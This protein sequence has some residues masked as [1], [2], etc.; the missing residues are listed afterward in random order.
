M[1]TNFILDL[2]IPEFENLVLDDIVTPIDADRLDDLLRRSNYP[3]KKRSHLV[4]G[5]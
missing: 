4:K 1:V 3:D 2:E 5:F